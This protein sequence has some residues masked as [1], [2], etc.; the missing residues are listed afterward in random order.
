[1][2]HEQI[3]ATV[4]PVH[5]LLVGCVAAAVPKANQIQWYWRGNFKPIIRSDPISKFLR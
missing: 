4:K 5:D 1:V 2:R 3:P